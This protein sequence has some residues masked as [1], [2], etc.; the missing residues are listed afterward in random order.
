MTLHR[1]L[2]RDAKFKNDYI[3][4]IETDLKLGFIRKLDEHEKQ[5]MKKLP[6]F[7]L[8]HFG[9]YHP[10]KPDKCRRVIDAAAK[11]NGVS[12]NTVLDSG[13]NI[14]TSLL[15]VTIRFRFGQYAVNADIDKYYSQVAVPKQQQYYLAFL[16]SPT[17][18]KKPDTYVYTRHPFGAACAPA[19]AISALHRSAEKHPTLE[20]YIKRSFYMDDF[21]LSLND[22]KLLLQTAQEI[23]HALAEDS[24]PLNKWISN[25][26]DIQTALEPES[27]SLL[28]KSFDYDKDLVP[29][30]KVLG[31]V[32]DCKTDTITFRSRVKLGDPPVKVRHALRML[33][34]TYDPLGIIAPFVL[35]GKKIWQE[36]W[37]AT[38][39]YNEAIPVDLATE[40]MKWMTGLQSIKALSIPRWLGF[41]RK[42]TP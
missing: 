34:A 16:W 33:A 39:D 20:S 10:D 31:M 37:L 7:Y 18:T 30:A 1:K 42:Q 32:W 2:D 19:A 28:E 35:K 21:Y 6:Y 11:I 26:L 17:P 27:V 4:T 29:P 3:G 14:L 22:K 38:K 5:E 36:I 13:P 12:L 40:F 15:G 25:D 8:P 9:V 41:Q 23:Q 24:F